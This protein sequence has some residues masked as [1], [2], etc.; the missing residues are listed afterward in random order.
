MRCFAFISS[1]HEY[2][3]CPDNSILIERN[4][5]LIHKIQF[6]RQPYNPVQIHKYACRSILEYVIMLQ[7]HIPLPHPVIDL[8]CQRSI[9]RNRRIDN[10]PGKICGYY[11]KKKNLYQNYILSIFRGF[12][13][14]ILSGN[15][16]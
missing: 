16:P 11:E 7:L 8:P 2:I 9:V 12:F 10:L 15:Y 14:L 1:V 5:A 3:N 13:L 4:L 6:I